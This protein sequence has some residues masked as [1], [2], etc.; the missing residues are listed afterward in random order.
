MTVISTKFPTI[1]PKFDVLRVKIVVLGAICS[2]NFQKVL[3]VLYTLALMSLSL[4]LNTMSNTH[5]L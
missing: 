2:E 4:A 1:G 3:N 5:P